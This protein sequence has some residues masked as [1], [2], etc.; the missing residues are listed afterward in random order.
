MIPSYDNY[1]NL[2]VVILLEIYHLFLFFFSSRRRHTRCALV[3]GVQTCALPICGPALQ[4]LGTLVPDRNV[5]ARL[6]HVDGVVL[7]AVDQEVPLFGEANRAVGEFARDRDGTMVIAPQEDHREE[8]DRDR[9][10]LA[11]GGGAR[12]EVVWGRNGSGGVGTDG[13]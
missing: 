12:K 2:L 3:T 4:S 1:F 6:E 13:G 9:H 5:P 8:Q 11:G 10:L 7:R